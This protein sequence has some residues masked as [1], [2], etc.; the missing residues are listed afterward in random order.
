MS[1][2]SKSTPPSRWKSEVSGQCSPAP[3]ADHSGEKPAQWIETRSREERED[4]SC[5]KP[6][7]SWRASR[8][9]VSKSRSRLKFQVSEATGRAGTFRGETWR[10]RFNREGTKDAKIPLILNSIEPWRSLRLCVSMCRSIL[11]FQVSAALGPWRF[12]SSFSSGIPG[13]I[14]GLLSLEGQ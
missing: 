11:K 14:T 5:F 2:V 3:R 9:C 8:L 1:E 7:R 4:S 6:K 12:K 10:E 13:S